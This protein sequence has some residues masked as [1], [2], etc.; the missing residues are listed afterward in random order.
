MRNTKI[1][2]SLAAL[3]V[4]LL[5]IGVGEYAHLGSTSP[6]T[7]LTT[8]I[9]A[10]SPTVRPAS[11]LPTQSEETVPPTTAVPQTTQSEQTVPLTTAVPKTTVPEQTVPLTA[12]VSRALTTS[13]SQPPRPA[14][15]TVPAPKPVPPTTPV[16]TQHAN[17]GRAAKAAHTSPPVRTAGRSSIASRSSIDSRGGR[18]PEVAGAPLHKAPKRGRADRVYVVKTHD[19]LWDIAATHLGNPERWSELFDLNRGRAEPGGSLVDP[20][21]IFRGWTL[22]FPAHG[23]NL[24]SK[25]AMQPSRETLYV[26]QPGDTLWDIAATHLGNPDRWS[27]LFDLNRGRAE[28]GG[29]LV[30][31][32]LIY[33]GWTLEFPAGATGLS[34]HTTSTGTISAQAP[35]Q[36]GA[37]FTS[38]VMAGVAHVMSHGLNIFGGGW[39]V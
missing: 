39:S 33:A 36:T 8:A 35:K 25:P 9:R 10:V 18:P 32:N 20:N 1:V 28:P 26:V 5:G 17:T 21:L 22:D 2:W 34:S 13:T 24:S 7:P 12:P 6:Q 19:T 31:P 14:R 30:S 16:S 23:A 3:T 38:T 15:T 37:V 11:P 4:M 29:Q 27:E